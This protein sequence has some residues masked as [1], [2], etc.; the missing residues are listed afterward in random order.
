MP[1]VM[2][3]KSNQAWIELVKR[4]LLKGE[5][6]EDKEEAKVIVRNFAQYVLMVE[7]LY[8]RG[9][10]KPLLKCVVEPKNTNVLTEIRSGSCGVH[11]GGQ[12]LSRLVFRADNYWPTVLVDA[13]KTVK[14]CEARQRLSPLRR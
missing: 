2:E 6:P 10:L 11:F 14:R 12:S 8:R 7:E 1:E 3:I 9:F 5:F 13:M 4:Y